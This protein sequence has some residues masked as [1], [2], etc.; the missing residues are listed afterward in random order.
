MPPGQNP[1]TSLMY[2]PVLV[3]DLP[4]PRGYIPPRPYSGTVGEEFAHLS[5]PEWVEWLYENMPGLL[6]GQGGTNP[7]T[8][9][10]AGSVAPDPFA[11]SSA[12]DIINFPNFNQ[13]TPAT[14]VVPVLPPAASAAMVRQPAPG[15]V[16]ALNV[17]PP[18]APMLPTAPTVLP[19]VN[20]AADRLPHRTEFPARTQDFYSQIAGPYNNLAVESLITGEDAAA[21][22]AEIQ[23]NTLMGGRINLGDIWEKGKDIFFSDPMQNFFQLSRDALAQPARFGDWG[24]E[25]FARAQVAREAATAA[26]Q[27]DTALEYLKQGID[28]TTGMPFDPDP[29]IGESWQADKLVELANAQLALDVVNKAVKITTGVK[30]TGVWATGWRGIKEIGE[31][32]GIDVVGRDKR[33]VLDS[34]RTQMLILLQQSGVFG[35]EISKVDEMLARTAWPKT[36]TFASMRELQAALYSLTPFLKTHLEAL[37]RVSRGVGPRFERLAGNLGAQGTATWDFREGPGGAPPGGV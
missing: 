29:I 15:G 6:S 14:P 28:P 31:A 2:P 34:L 18:G 22:D 24:V 16:S 25:P 5:T 23:Q 7:R 33:Q 32:L 11:G 20:V 3:E 17:E 36:G 27:Q 13:A 37:E 1:F 26:A 9:R 35:R 4:P 12:K 10:A 8:N 21:A 30:L 19:T